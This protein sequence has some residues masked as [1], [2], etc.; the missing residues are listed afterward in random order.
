M[1]W[2]FINPRLAEQYY[3]YAMGETAENVAEKYGVS[4]VDQDS[5]A[6]RSHQRAVAAQ[7]SGRFTAE[8]VPVTIP[9]KKGEPMEQ[10]P[11]S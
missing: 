6:L 1:N 10:L 4:R 2:R 9:H 7:Q 3:P 11:W 8:I 5:F